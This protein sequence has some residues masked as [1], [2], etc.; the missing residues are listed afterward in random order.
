MKPEELFDKL[1]PVLSDDEL[2]DVV[3]RFGVGVSVA[4][5]AKKVKLSA[6]SAARRL[7]RLV[8]AG[9]LVKSSNRKTT[10]PYKYYVVA[11]SRYLKRKEN[12]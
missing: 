2:L 10:R 3:K 1:S 5:V 8:D 9:Y 6:N 4:T 11:S 12:V 7:N